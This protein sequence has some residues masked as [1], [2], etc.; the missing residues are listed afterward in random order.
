MHCSLNEQKHIWT[1]TAYK[2]IKENHTKR[3]Q[4]A[5]LKYTD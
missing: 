4:P 3:L 5:D 1:G 2:T